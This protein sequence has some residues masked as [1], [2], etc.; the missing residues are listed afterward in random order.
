MRYNFTPLFFVPLFVF[1]QM[2]LN[3]QAVDKADSAALVDLYNS[4][5]GDA[6][7]NHDN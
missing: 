7:T 4:T 6:W 3:A 1:A 2:K 5:K